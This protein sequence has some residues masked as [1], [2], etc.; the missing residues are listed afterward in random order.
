ME[1]LLKFQDGSQKSLM[2]DKV[3]TD[4]YGRVIYNRHDLYELLYQGVDLSKLDQVEWH[5]D[6]DKY[7]AALTL[8]HLS[9][10]PLQPLNNYS[11]DVSEFDIE[12]QRKWFVPD[13]YMKMDICSYVKNKTPLARMKRVETELELYDKYELLDVLRLCVYLVDQMRKHNVVWGV[14]RGSSVASYVLYVIG[15]HKIDSE[16][17]GLDIREF[18]K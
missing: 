6:F 11:V 10:S 14:G 15:I 5:E 4:Q 9:D 1:K 17:Y 16:K 7:N 2:I 18:L 3:T 12:H 8:N 13:E